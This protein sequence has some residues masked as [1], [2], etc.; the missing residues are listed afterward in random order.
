MSSDLVLIVDDNEDNRTIY[1]VILQHNGLDVIVAADGEEAVRQALTHRPAVILMD[2]ALP[3]IDGLEATRQ[4]KRTELLRD[5]PVVAITAMDRRA[6]PGDLGGAGFC[7]WL[8]KP[9]PPRDVYAEI[10]RVL[11]SRAVLPEVATNEHSRPPE[12]IGQP[13]APTLSEPAGA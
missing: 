8:T 2:I 9:V 13:A 1:S 7:A 3:G 11:S 4:I 6:G 10:A 5:T 12:S